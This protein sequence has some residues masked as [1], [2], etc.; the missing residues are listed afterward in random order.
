VYQLNERHQEK[1]LDS[2]KKEKDDSERKDNDSTNKVPE[3]D[4]S[5]LTV[6]A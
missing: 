2:G 1:S 3:K 6:M 4:A 5:A